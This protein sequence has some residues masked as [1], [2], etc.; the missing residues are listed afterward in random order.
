MHFFLRDKPPRTFLSFLRRGALWVLLLFLLPACAKAPISGRSQLLLMPESHEIQLGEQ[1]FR[2]VKQKQRISRDPEKNAMVQRVGRRIAAVSGKA[3]AYRWEFI[4]I[5]D[6]APNA[7]ALPGG[8]VAVNTGMFV[9]ARDE[10]G[11]A[12]VLGHEVAHA[13]ARH[14][15]ERLSQHL[16]VSLGLQAVQIGMSRQDPYIV[17]QVAGLLGAGANIGI[18]LPFSRAHESEADRLGLT[19]M[20][21][22]GYDP[23]AAVD[24][25][26]RMEA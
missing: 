9:I 25:W 2:E 24:F 19:Y 10:A 14:G 4:V 15:G 3:H 7:F 8:K 5:E 12:T 18:L 20:A 17:R 22:A 23:R 1:T 21:K 16:I 6:H 26:Q 13:I 11:L